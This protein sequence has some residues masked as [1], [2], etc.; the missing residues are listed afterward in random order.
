MNYFGHSCKVWSSVN[1][2]DTDE[3]FGQVGHGWMVWSQV[4]GLAFGHGWTVRSQVKG[5][6]TDEQFGNVWKVLIN[7]LVTDERF[8]HWWRVWSPVNGF[9]HRCRVWSDMNGLV[10][11]EQCDHGWTV[12]S[13]LSWVKRLAPGHGWTVRS[14]VK[15]F[16][17]GEMFAYRWFGNVWEVWAWINSL[18]TDERFGHWW[19][20][21]ACFGTLWPLVLAS[22]Y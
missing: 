18:G 3:R 2:L 7:G 21:R 20:R 6:V 22:N 17:T 19:T 12:W 16:V 14:R 9:V 1:G 10:T 4:N 5:F 8:D 11:D 15:S 13:W